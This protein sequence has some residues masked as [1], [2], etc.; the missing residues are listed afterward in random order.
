MR[1][2]S[3][4]SHLIASLFKTPH[5]QFLFGR[6]VYMRA[7]KDKLGLRFSKHRSLRGQLRMKNLRQSRYREQTLRGK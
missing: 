6:A 3:Y 5:P 2:R 1:R 7:K 4:L